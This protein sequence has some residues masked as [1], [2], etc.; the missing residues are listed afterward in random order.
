MRSTRSS[1]AAGG[2]QP[3]PQR[4]GWGKGDET[5][6][7]MFEMEYYDMTEDDREALWGKLE[8]D[9]DDDTAE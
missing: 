6:Y 7:G 2:G 8:D 9:E 4:P 5:M 1:H 3:P